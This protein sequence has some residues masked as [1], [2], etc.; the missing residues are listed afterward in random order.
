M[1]LVERLATEH[2]A[3][4]IYHNVDTKKTLDKARAIAEKQGIVESST[5][6]AGRGRSDPVLKI[7]GSIPGARMSVPLLAV[8]DAGGVLRYAGGGGRKL[9]DVAAA[10]GK[11]P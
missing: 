3:T 1:P 5:P 6:M 10:L 7:L 8:V 4:V 2:G 9:A 11:R